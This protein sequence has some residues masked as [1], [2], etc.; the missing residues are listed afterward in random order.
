MNNTGGMPSK[1]V[2]DKVSED[3]TLEINDDEIKYAEEIYKLFVEEGITPPAK[4]LELGS[5]SGHLSAYLAQKGYKVALL[6]FSKGALKKSEETFALYGLDGEFI[7]GDLFDLSKVTE[8]YDFVWNSGVMEHFDDKSLKKIFYQISTLLKNKFVFFVPNPD[9]ISYLL[10]RYNLEGQGRWA[11]GTEYFR[12]NYLDIAQ[13]VGLNGRILGYAGSSIS[14]WHFESTF[15]Q[16]DNKSIYASLIDNGIM[17]S[18]ESYL[19]AYI[20]ERAPEEEGT[21][22]NILS[23][24]NENYIEQELF[25][26]KSA[27]CYYEKKKIDLL[28][29][30]IHQLE[31]NLKRQ[32]GETEYYKTESQRLLEANQTSEKRLSEQDSQITVLEGDKQ[33]LNHKLANKSNEAESVAKQ[34]EELNLKLAEAEKNQDIL[35]VQLKDA[36]AALEK[37]R[38]KADDIIRQNAELNIKI[39]EKDKLLSEKENEFQLIC[40]E[41]IEKEKEKVN[42]KELELQKANE[43]IKDDE[44]KIK[45]LQDENHGMFL[46]INDVCNGTLPQVMSSIWSIHSILGAKWFSR[47]IALHAI[48]GALVAEPFINKLKI[49]VKLFLRIFGVKYDFLIDKYRMN[50]K[51][52]QY[53]G[54]IENVVQIARI[55]IA[56]PVEIAD[57]AEDKDKE[58]KEEKFIEQPEEIIYAQ[59]PLVS[60][61]LPVYNHADYILDAISGVQ[62]QSYTNWELIIL[63]DGS[64]DGLLD[65][66]KDYTNDPRIKIYTQDNQRLPNGLSNLHN[67]ASGEFITWTSADNVMKETMLSSLVQKLIEKP[68]A[69]MVFADVAIIDNKGEFVTQGYRE[70]NRDMEFPYIMRLPHS[71]DALDAEADNYINACF[72]Y[73]AQPVKA[74]KGL[75]SADLEGLE[76]YDFWL[77]LRTF[78]SIVHVGNKEPLYCYRVHENTMSEDLLKNKLEEHAKRAKKMIEYSQKKDAFAEKNWQIVI[79]NKAQYAYEFENALKKT[80]YAYERNSGKT[81]FYVQEANLSNLRDKQIAVVGDQNSYRIYVKNGGKLEERAQIYR[82]FDINPLA[83]KVRQTFIRGLFWEYPAEFVNMKVLGC[84]LDLSYIDI[85]KTVELLN[86]NQD[87]LFSFC[88]L[89]GTES[90]EVEEKISRECKNAIFMGERE[91]GTQMY[92]Y[93]SWD[94]VFIPPLKVEMDIMPLIILGWN[95]GRWILIDSKIMKDTLPFVSGY[96]YGERLLGIKK[97]FQIGKVEDILDHYILKYSRIGAIHQ[98]ISYL[99]GIGQDIMVKRPDFKLTYKKRV[100]PPELIQKQYVIEEKL[101]N[102]YIGLMVDS[103]DKGGLEQVVALLAREL[104][105]RGLMVR[106]LCTCCG[107][108]VA[109]ELSEEGFDVEVF[110]NDAKRFEMYLKENRPLLINT[111]YTKKMLDLVYSLKIPIIEVIHNMYVFHNDEAIRREKELSKYYTKMI[112]VSSIVKEIYLKKVNK[113]ASDKIVVVGNAANPSKI[114]GLDRRYVRE[115]L[116]IKQNSFVFINVSSIDSR[117]NQMGLVKAFELFNQ[118]VSKNSYLI[119]VGNR[120]SEFYDNALEELISSVTCKNNIIKLDYH[121]AVG[122]LYSAADVFV[123]P[124]YYEGWSIAAT[125]ALYSGLPIIHSMCGSAKELLNNGENG[126]MISNPAGDITEWKVDELLHSMNGVSSSNVEELREAMKKMYEKKEEWEQK[127]GEISAR[128]ILTYNIDDMV[129]NYIRE[130]AD[131][132]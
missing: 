79:D 23:S 78:G 124:S 127:R 48:F 131:V 97:I 121:N 1:E 103:L 20:V 102:G 85:E 19:I 77:R 9:S 55:N 66:I 43:T 64:T 91:F 21:E 52:I 57:K 72:M 115:L 116:G 61:L 53:L 111:H 34:N 35:A 51:I 50:T 41:A 100:F 12:R 70:M 11:Y 54:N 2:W 10:M 112:A 92:L 56:E 40:A 8:E 39:L 60:V 122:D 125:E 71:T 88:S 36:G 58:E 46:K 13:T 68:D 4:L 108:E 84:H 86:N 29:T 42:E 99:N 69:I 65:I 83:K 113:E 67:L 3:Y 120:L 75:Y 27:E 18:N 109:R 101:K 31:E 62:H 107:G 105:K 94:A 6:D 89:E 132:I 15:S 47:V 126:I 118:T 32:T 129:S 25:F 76:D 37:E 24:Q 44:G 30:E 119:I 128:S 87:I 5:G 90:K 16:D 98:I 82:G 117:K 114:T 73:R 14:I 110:D 49:L 93:A 7:E 38:S 17:P 26:T 123:M 81:A 28:T 104:K 22:N 59:E 63:N 45:T 106:V 95:I 96:Y 130:F 74:L 33:D 80:N